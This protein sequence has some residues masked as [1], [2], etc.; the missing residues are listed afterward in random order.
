M[1]VQALET[2]AVLGGLDLAAFG[3]HTADHVHALIETIKLA[4]AD[5][6][7]DAMLDPSR[8]WMSIA[9]STG[10]DAVAQSYQDVVAGR[11][12]PDQGHVFSLSNA[13]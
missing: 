5:I 1:N 6:G 9:S 12:R 8:N 11:A 3:L 13:A 4:Q 2:L 10:P 7:A